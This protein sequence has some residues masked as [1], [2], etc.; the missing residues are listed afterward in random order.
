MYKSQFIL[1]QNLFLLTLKEYSNSINLKNSCFFFDKKKRIHVKR[2]ISHKKLYFIK[3]DNDSHVKNIF[4]E[5]HLDSLTKNF[6]KSLNYIL[7][8][9][10]IS[11]QYTISHI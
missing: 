4:S 6:I 5:D 1:F 9:Q 3:I 10:K 8:I 2:L 7:K 11:I